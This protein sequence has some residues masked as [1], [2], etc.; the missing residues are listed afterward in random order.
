MAY[1]DNFHFELIGEA[2]HPKLVFLH[3]VMG[4]ASNWRKVIAAFAPRYQ[5]L[6][7]DQRGH[8]KSFHPQTGYSPQDYAHDL[9][10]ILDELGWQQIFLV[11]HSMGGRNALAF[12]L[13]FS[14]RVKALVVE[15][16]APARGR[17]QKSAT[18]ELIAAVPVPFANRKAAKEFFL[19]DFVRI[20]ADRPQIHT[21]GQFFYSNITEDEHGRATWR[22]Y[23]PGILESIHAASSVANN[24]DL[25]QLAVPTLWIR[26]QYSDELS[27]DEYA[28]I[29]R[30][31][32]FIQGIEV[33]NAGHWVH[34]DQ[35][36]LFITAVDE[37]LAQVRTVAKGA[38]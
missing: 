36:E 5:V 22:F 38:L 20:F 21:V 2:A 34:S 30:A 6:A 28:T 37:F 18:E 1:L 4:Y 13:Q 8:G 26:G 9:Q 15:D 10:L 35:P 33:A 19:N 7:F 16:I 23:L 27:P 14:H 17:G 32:P 11:G 12:A 29:L 25:T 31:S 3:G 24:A